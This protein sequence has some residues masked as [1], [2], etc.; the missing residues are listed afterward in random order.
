MVEK[1][2]AMLDKDGSGQIQAKDVINIYDVKNI[3]EFKDGKKSK[4]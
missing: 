3:K 2:F 1:A 4:E